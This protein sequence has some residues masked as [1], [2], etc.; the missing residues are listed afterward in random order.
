MW[1]KS[2]ALHAIPLGVGG[3]DESV[4]LKSRRREM[5][6]DDSALGDSREI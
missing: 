4:G 2:G 3:F 1:L 5:V 6:N